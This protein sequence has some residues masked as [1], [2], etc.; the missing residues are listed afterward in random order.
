MFGGAGEI[1]HVF[2]AGF[3]LFCFSV[4]VEPTWIS[5]W[6]LQAIVVGGIRFLL[7]EVRLRSSQ[8]AE[9]DGAYVLLYILGI[10]AGLL[11]LCL[12]LQ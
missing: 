6:R 11:N 2:F 7:S 12:G 5:N 10:I 8:G 1:A 3:T 4:G 9:R